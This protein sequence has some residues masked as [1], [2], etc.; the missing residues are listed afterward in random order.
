MDFRVAS[1]FGKRRRTE[2]GRLSLTEQLKISQFLPQEM[3]Q[4]DAENDNCLQQ[5]L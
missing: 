4:I 1:S 3:Q 2:F 5:W